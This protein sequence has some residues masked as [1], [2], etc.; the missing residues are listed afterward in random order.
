MTYT[1]TFQE[2]VL[3]RLGRIEERL[4]PVPELHGRLT[5]LEAQRNYVAGI[6]GFVG[7]LASY[8]HLKG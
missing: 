1:A 8:L 7:F 2:D 4:T 3:E 6:L 5:K